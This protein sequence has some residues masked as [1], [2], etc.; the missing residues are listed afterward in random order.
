MKKSSSILI[1]TSLLFSTTVLAG[2]KTNLGEIESLG[3]KWGK[4]NSCQ[5]S[6]LLGYASYKE[7]RLGE[8]KKYF[9]KC[10]SKYPILQKYITE[11]LSKIESGGETFVYFNK[12]DMAESEIESLERENDGSSEA[13]YNLAKGYFK[14]RYY[15]KA[16]E[17]FSK[18]ANDPNYRLGS[19]EYL[20]TSYARR[21]KYDE[22]VETNR[23]IMRE[24]CKN[25]NSY[26]KAL[27]KLAFLLLDGGKYSEALQRYQEVRKAFPRLQ[28]EQVEWFIAWCEYKLGNFNKAAS[29][30]ELISKHSREKQKYRGL[31][32]QAMALK[33]AGSKSKANNI[34]KKIYNKN[35]YSYYGF[36]AAKELGETVPIPKMEDR[37]GLD[38][39]KKPKCEDGDPLATAK[40]L[41]FLEVQDLVGRELFSIIEAPSAEFDWDEVYRLAL[42]NNSWHIVNLLGRGKLKNFLRNNEDEEENNYLTNWEASYP[43]A[44]SKMVNEFAQINGVEPLLIWSV[45]REESAF[46]PAIISA[47]GAVG[48]MQL[49]PKTAKRMMHDKEFKII[50]LT[51]PRYNIEAGVR[52]L[53]FLSQRYKNIFHL[54]AAGYNAGEEAVD[55]WVSNEDLN[56]I[57]IT[58]FVEEI[59]Y[60]ETQDYVRKVIRSYW[61]YEM[62]YSKR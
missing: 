57:N 61:I 40:E 23:I 8:V 39:G 48:L 2:I 18:T 5:K 7:G 34:F 43:K 42:K 11:F 25:K 55:R 51:Y 56:K 30:F 46:K 12:Q 17:L 10:D 32:W 3:K 9:N 21:D 41:D 49:M 16:A 15:D 62:L 47:A 54:V 28:R 1:I 37:R 19:L 45:M 52:Y 53:A 4:F 6:F 29:F 31:F 20:A 50:Y 33:D 22:A 60:K 35:K 58:E 27:S 13:A 36:L 14:G 26:S 44:H 38:D 24:F 59:P